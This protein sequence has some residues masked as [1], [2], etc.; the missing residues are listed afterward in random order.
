MGR[1]RRNFL[2]GE[3]GRE[4]RLLDSKSIMREKKIGGEKKEGFFFLGERGEKKKKEPGPLAN[5]EKGKRA[6][7]GSFY[8]ES[9]K[10]EGEF[11]HFPKGHRGKLEAVGPKKSFPPQGG[12]GT[13]RGEGG[14]GKEGPL[15]S[16]EKYSRRENH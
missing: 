6:K 9:K 13:L 10:K 8:L 15:L 2:R 14:K 11:P 4:K 3:R 7:G 5:G 16:W 12:R 1:K